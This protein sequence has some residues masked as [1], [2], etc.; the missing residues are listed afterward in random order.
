[1][2]D[3]YVSQYRRVI[4]NFRKVTYETSCRYSMTKKNSS[5]TSKMV[6]DKGFVSCDPKRKWQFNAN[7]TLMY[8]VI[9]PETLHISP[10]LHKS[11]PEHQTDAHLRLNFDL[12]S[13]GFSLFCLSKIV[14]LLIH[15][16]WHDY[17]SFITKRTQSQK[18]ATYSKYMTFRCWLQWLQVSSL[19]IRVLSISESEEYERLNLL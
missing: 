15:T 7:F 6:V 19:K 5:V 17:V 9:H 12:L 8:L 13:R 4:N 2:L 18:Y 1:V 3:H 11:F 16:S 10:G 14:T